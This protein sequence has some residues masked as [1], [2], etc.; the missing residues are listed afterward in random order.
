MPQTDPPSPTSP[1]QPLDG[2]R[3][4]DL[5]R[6]LP[7]PFL[8]MVLADMGA[9]VSKIEAPGAGDYLRIM[10]PL[11]GAM[12]GRFLALN[13]NKRSLVLNLKAAQQRDAFL[14]MVELA[15]VVVE[16]F[17][18][19]V[20]DSLGIGFE[21][22]KAHNPKI[23]LASISGYGQD[24]LYRERA[25]HDLNYIA[26]SGLLA[27]TGEAGA[28]PTMPGTQ[29]A[30]LA[31]G[32][33]WASTA[34]LGALLGR[35]RCGAQHL[36]ISMCEGSLALLAAE[37]G[38]MQCK[39][40]R[41]TRGSEMLNGALACYSVYETKDRKHLSVGALEPKFWLAFN[42]A[43]GRKGNAA[44][45]ALGPEQQAV[46]RSEVAEILRGKSRSEWVSI[47]ADFDCCTE[48]V[49][50]LNE[51]EEHPLHKSR[52]LFFTIATDAGDLHQI[53]TPVGHPQQSSAPPSH[54]Q[55]S[56]EILSDYGLSES[57]IEQILV[58]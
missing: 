15:D 19:G 43:I 21:S 22:L 2:I 31:G 6:L 25:G 41:P 36:D 1:T 11:Q 10:P 14:K 40:E 13:R 53:R 37:L 18:P 58:E 38:N 29:V 26:L 12:S 54:G 34:I 49:L 9:D 33:L 3:V 42:E 17:R 32:A 4:L 35:E 51:L 57:A 52:N 20:M 16:S 48:A 24:G 30:D 47:L 8:T 23:I 46:I 27:M 56:R 44:E 55:H 7:G 45:V 5:S 28:K 39:K 50:E